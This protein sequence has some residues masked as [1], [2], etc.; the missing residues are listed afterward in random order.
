LGVGS[1][2]A[3]AALAIVTMPEA[4]MDEDHGAS[5]RKHQ[6]RLSWQR[7]AVQP[8]SV[9]CGVQQASDDHFRFGILGL[10][11]LHGAPAQRLKRLDH[12]RRIGVA[13]EV[14]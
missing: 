12:F 11:C 4:A 13:R 5:T 2:H 8:I 10:D 3:R 1:R 9:A 6:V 14:C 7:C